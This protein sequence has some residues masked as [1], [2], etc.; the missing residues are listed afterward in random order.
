MVA[1]P[2][3]GY[4]TI[5]LI[6]T[7]A[8]A[9][10]YE[11]ERKRDGKRVLAKVFDV[12]DAS[13]EAQVEHEFRLLEAL[14]IEGVVRALG[15]ERAGHQLVL[16]LDFVAGRNLEQQAG[17]E[18]VP[19]ERFL[20]Q[21][22][23]MAATLARIHERRI[24]H[25]DIKPSNILVEH[26]TGRIV[27]ADFGISVLLENERRHLYDPD[28]LHGTLPYVSPEQTGRTGREVDFRSDLYSLGA[29]FYE[30]LTGR[31][32]FEGK[33][34]LELIHAHLAQRPRSPRERVASIPSR[35]AAIVLKLLEKPPEHRYQSARGLHA[36]LVRLSEALARGEVD[37]EFL[38]GE[39]D[40]GSSLQMPHQLYGRER[41]R[42]VL[43]AEL[44]ATI[45]SG[46]PRLVLLGGAAGTGKSS[47]IRTIEAPLSDHAGY[48]GI[49]KS[50]Q[51]AATEELPY[52]GFAQ[53]LTGVIGQLLAESDER[54]SD[55]RSR[56][57]AKLGPIA[58]VVGA[59][60]PELALVIGDMPPVPEVELGEAR[61]RLRLA[62]TRLIATLAETAPLVLVLDDLQWA[63]AG[64]LELL[65]ALLSGG[66]ALGPVLVLGA[67]RSDEVDERH[68]LPRTIEQLEAESVPVLRMSMTPLPDRALE[69]ML[70]DVFGRTIDEVA[71]LTAVIGRKTENNPFFVRQYLTSLAELGLVRPGEGGWQWQLDE[72]ANASI[73]DDL[74]GVMRA[75][76]ERLAEREREVLQRAACIGARFEVAVLESIAELPSDELAASLHAL[77]SEGLIARVE[78]SARLAFR[79]SHDRIQASAL[80]CLEP[81]TRRRMHR[82]IARELLGRD[83]LLFEI[84]DQF[85]QSIDDVD[86][87]SE[88]ERETV[89]KLALE[90]GEQAL[91]SAA[92]RS[93]LR[94]LEFATALFGE[95]RDAASFAARFAR[96]QALALVGE[97]TQ[98]EQ[99]FEQ[100]LGWSLTQVDR[101]RVIARRVQILR[102]QDRTREAVAHG[103]AGL[104][105]C[106]VRLPAKPSIP[107]MLLQVVQA[108]QKVKGADLQQLRAL[109]EV[110]DEQT[111]ATL[112]LVNAIKWPAFSAE[113]QLYVYLTALHTRLVMSKGFHPTAVEGIAQ[114][115]FVGLAM[116]QIE[117][118]F[119]LCRTVIELA[120]KRETSPSSALAAEAL[121][122]MYIGPTARPF[123]EYLRSN[124]ELYERALL[125]GDRL[126]AGYL[127]AV[128][129]QLHV[130]AGGHLREI[131]ELDAR[132]S[133]NDA[134]FGAIEPRTIAA[135]V[136]AFAATLGA[137]QP[138]DAPGFFASL[139]GQGISQATKVGAVAIELLGRVLLGELE[140]GWQLAESVAEGY[141][142]ALVGIWIA[143]RFAL[144]D[145]IVTGHRARAEPGVR[146][147]LI[148]RMEK[149]LATLRKFADVCPDN[150]GSGVD[151]VLAE[152]A[153]TRGE[154]HEAF[155]RLERARK[156]AVASQRVYMEAIACRRLAALAEQQD[157]TTVREG[158][159]RGARDALSRWGAW[160]A[161]RQLEQEHPTLVTRALPDR[162]EARTLRHSHEE[163]SVS[164]LD[165]ASVL[166]T[167]QV[168]SEDLRL[169]EVIPRVLAG[170]IENAGAD[171][172]ALL[173]ERAGSVALVAEGSVEAESNVEYL[174]PPIALRDAEP[175]L[176]TSVVHYVLRTGEPL[177]VDD[178][179]SDARFAADPYVLSSGVRSLLCMPIVKQQARVGAL[180]LENRLATRAFTEHRLETL[181][182]LLG[183][184]ASALDNARLYAQ[185]ERSEAQW[186]SLVDGVPDTI[187]LLDKQGRIEFVNHREPDRGAAGSFAG[188]DVT[189]FMDAASRAA[190]RTSFAEVV[191]TGEQREL[192]VCVARPGAPLRFFMTRITR[193]RGKAE[194]FLA[195][196]TD[197]TARKRLEAQVR[198]QQ[199]LESVGTLASGVAHEINNPVQGIMNYA[200]LI[201]AQVD[202]P[203]TVLEFAGEITHESKR[204]AAIV[205]NLL[206][207]ARQEGEGELDEADVRELVDTTLS[208]IHAVLRKDQ[209]TVALDIPDALLPVRC[210]AQQIQ[211][212]IMNL[213]T[214]ARDA[215]NERYSGFDERKH[216]DILAA[217]FERE[218]RRWVR[219]S[220]V[221][222]ATGIPD[223]V[224]ARIFDPFFTTKG[225]DQGTGLG[226]AVS[227]K[228]ATDHG[229]DLWV[230]SEVGV[231]SRFHL[232]LPAA[233]PMPSADPARLAGAR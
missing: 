232:D 214:N 34:P 162:S 202:D 185:L 96:A 220:V 110:R 191:A 76:L 183:Q 128:C 3:A 129:M 137:E 57:R 215:L 7:T 111:I 148:R 107:Q 121:M 16:L 203:Q 113:P 86:A 157:W 64:T 40:F 144:L 58:G 210:R 231:G 186:R 221:D 229:G 201:S 72:I 224:R 18:P 74:V 171:R 30:L 149:R 21:A 29:T 71:P 166:A 88:P 117:A 168:I 55:W 10:V 132:L 227:H 22:C 167:M 130:E 145:A 140:R 222:R 216:I 228:I 181:K 75:K 17:G 175:R 84:V 80:D 122:A 54:L 199:R 13:A 188:V 23:E 6:R 62:V 184:A 65:G 59:L 41:E 120:G 141:E 133:R 89:A 192:E 125:A 209:I 164:S 27:F 178:A 42:E 155:D 93:A 44:E 87:L 103:L 83:E 230:E 51:P 53:A 4:T 154:V 104:E 70:A 1:V 78:G 108:W 143:P 212:I 226:L 158:A 46:T 109:P 68:P 187:A 116:G 147:R 156:A 38:L 105:R 94:D 218:G 189:E 45:R 177:V 151:L 146:R 77:E 123:R 52:R 124:L 173:L 67:H 142:Q 119:R 33:A 60:V 63:D 100:L 97:E 195:I 217:A 56:L 101:A 205:R 219:L 24:V 39:R 174:D 106:G 127:G 92:W 159:L 31:Q 69:R 114:L 50:S 170:A 5:R 172:G 194:R 98:A 118:A 136:R 82:A 36:D 2:L 176:P 211:Q 95:R 112:D 169:E 160:T 126:H 14:D 43:E 131:V 179:R 163:T 153:W 223:D 26:A 85:R 182:I 152:I 165:L 233:V 20:P 32:P 200:E 134:S 206:S 91:R 190:W 150:F 90:A 180:V 48:I 11:A 81:A 28:I 208:L 115:A 8:R 9:Q 35:L 139:E 102:M 47:L 99:A 207:F 19:L 61:N 12:D 204:V 73:P 161:V 15:I 37:P 66:A 25:R 193:I 79:F 196:S 225:R 135:F 213:V 198:Q 138:E 197:I 49:G